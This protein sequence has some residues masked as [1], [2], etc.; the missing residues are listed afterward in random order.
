MGHRETTPSRKARGPRQP[1]ATRMDTGLTP[2]S[3]TSAWPEAGSSIQREVVRTPDAPPRPLLRPC[4]CDPWI[5]I[6]F[7]NVV[8]LVLI[9]PVC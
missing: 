2:S 7:F 4:A 8:S 3:L 6:V 1:D 5:N 9:S